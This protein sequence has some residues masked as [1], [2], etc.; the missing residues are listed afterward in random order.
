MALGEKLAGDFSLRM[1][2]SVGRLANECMPNGLAR[3]LFD[4]LFPFALPRGRW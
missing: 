3:S 1:Y 4:S 2:D